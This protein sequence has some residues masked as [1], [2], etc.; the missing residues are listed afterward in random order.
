MGLPALDNLVRVGQLKLEPANLEVVRKFTF[1]QGLP[2]RQRHCV[3]HGQS[4]QD[5]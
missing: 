5:R 3:C 1:F 4:V 2:V